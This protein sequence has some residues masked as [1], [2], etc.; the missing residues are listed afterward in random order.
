MASKDITAATATEA[1]IAALK[2]AIYDGCASI[3]EDD[4]NAVF[5]QQDLLDFG[6]I[7]KGDV[8]LLLKVTQ[9]LIDE[10]LFKIVVDQDGMGWKFR[11]QEEAKK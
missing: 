4:P 6:V 7:P 3:I 11:T 1:D 10:K 2:T 9:A 8:V 5:H